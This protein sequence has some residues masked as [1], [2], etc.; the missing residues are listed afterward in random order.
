MRLS[1][2]FW[3]RAAGSMLIVGGIFALVVDFSSFRQALGSLTAAPLIWLALAVIM[4]LAIGICRWR[5][6][7]RA[8]GFRRTFI[9]VG[10]AFLIGNGLNVLI[11]SGMVGELAKAYLVS[12][13]PARP[14]SRVLGTIAIDRLVG[15]IGL[16]IALAATLLIPSSSGTYPGGF[17]FAVHPGWILPAIAVGLGP[18]AVLYLDRR[19]PK[20]NGWLRARLASLALVFKTVFEFKG[21]VRTLLLVLALTILGHLTLAAAIWNLAQIFA[22]MP[23]PLVVLTVTAV[24][25]VSLLPITINGLGTREVVFVVLFGLAGI[26]PGQAATV[27]LVWFATTFT[28]SILLAGL[29]GATLPPGSR[30]WWRSD[31]SIFARTEHHTAPK[32]PID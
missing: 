25:L 5:L 32:G 31:P 23:L 4:T 24:F 17:A 19:L 9:E 10:R 27:S 12:E 14:A 15:L 13:P 21:H 30:L 20:S 18:L 16:L 6:L 26:T 22:V 28:L 1:L 29:A 8:L 3:V 7:L 2:A 11:P